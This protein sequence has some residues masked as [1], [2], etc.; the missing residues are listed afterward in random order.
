LRSGRAAAVPIFTFFIFQREATGLTFVC[1]DW[2]SRVRL[3]PESA[4]IFHIEEPVM[5]DLG[6]PH[7]VFEKM[8]AK[9]LAELV[10][11]TAEYL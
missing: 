10:R 8:G 1:C 7:E 9:T 6:P 5:G 11:M 4:R 2:R 3:N